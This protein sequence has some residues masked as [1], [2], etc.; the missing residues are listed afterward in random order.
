MST[1]LPA[2]KQRALAAYEKQQAMRAAEARQSELE[3]AAILGKLLTAFG[4]ECEPDAHP[5]TLEGVTFRVAQYEEWQPYHLQIRRVCA[6]CGDVPGADEWYTIHNLTELGRMLSEPW[7]C[8][9]YA[10]HRKLQGQP[11][12]DPATVL[13]EALRAFIAAEHD[14]A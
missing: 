10:A 5:Y 13:V 8:Y 14:N 1:T 9:N 6:L 7:K 12:D 2:W 11:A 3:Q 4:I